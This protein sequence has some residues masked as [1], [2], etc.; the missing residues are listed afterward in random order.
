MIIKA[1]TCLTLLTACAMPASAQVKTAAPRISVSAPN[2]QALVLAIARQHPEARLIGLHV[3]A[4]NGKGNAIIACT[5][6]GRVGKLS[7]TVDL[8]IIGQP[9][10]SVAIDQKKQVYEAMLPIS[11]ASGHA[12]GMVVEQMPI[13]S[14]ADE[15]SALH[16]ALTI[17]ADLQ[18]GIKSQAWLFQAG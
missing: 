16:T 18:K 14:T 12:I 8:A 1:V 10:M 17:R 13:S 11:D 2:A 3:D 15:S 4:P 6:P 5:D 9:G 7:S